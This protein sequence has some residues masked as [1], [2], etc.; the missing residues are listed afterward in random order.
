MSLHSYVLAGT[1]LALSVCQAQSGGVRD[2]TTTTTKG[3]LQPW[4]V[5]LAAVVGFLVFVFIVLIAKR[6]LFGRDD[7]S[8]RRSSREE[9]VE[10]FENKLETVIEEEEDDVKQ[11]VL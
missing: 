2:T 4:L 10:G 3:R 6:L 5:G 7:S 1:L 9:D 8:S 11:T